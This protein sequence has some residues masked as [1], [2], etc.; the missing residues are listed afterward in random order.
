MSPRERSLRHAVFTSARYDVVAYSRTYQSFS[1]ATGAPVG[2]PKVLGPTDPAPLATA[3]IT[4]LVIT[5]SVSYDREV[6]C[7][8]W[9]IYDYYDWSGSPPN[10]GA[11][12]DQTAT[13][14]ANNLALLS[15]SAYGTYTGGWNI[16]VNR[17]DMTP[18]VGTSWEFDECNWR[19]LFC[20]SYADWGYLAAGIYSTSRHYQATNVAFKYFHTWADVSYSISFGAGGGSIT[21]SPTTNTSSTATYASFTD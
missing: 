11:G 5:T 8:H 10:G 1:V 15:D 14:W 7:C 3:T 2:G 4:N 16:S 17:N 6:A 21:I 13:S 18:N 20:Q 19:V 9:D 12:K